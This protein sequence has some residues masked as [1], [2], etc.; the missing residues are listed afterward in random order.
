MRRWSSAAITARRSV[1]LIVIQ[2]PIS[3]AVRPQPMQSADKGSMTQTLMQGVEIGTDTLSY[4]GGGAPNEKPAPGGDL[5]ALLR[6]S[7][8]VACLPADRTAS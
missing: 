5:G 7:S 6:C 4:L 2:A 1:S 3:A 8:D